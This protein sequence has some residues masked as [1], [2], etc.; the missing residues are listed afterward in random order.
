VIL[1]LTVTGAGLLGRKAM[2]C[3][4]DLLAAGQHIRA[5]ETRYQLTSA[6]PSRISGNQVGAHG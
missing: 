1:V 5:A 4:L 3:W 6:M 2:T